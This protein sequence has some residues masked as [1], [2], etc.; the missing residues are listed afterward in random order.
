M[1]REPFLKLFRALR[2]TLDSDDGEAEPGDEEML[3][4]LDYS[5]LR[6]DGSPGFLN[7]IEE[8]RRDVEAPEGLAL[9]HIVETADLLDV[10]DSGVWLLVPT[11]AA[12]LDALAA[13]EV[14]AEDREN[15]IE[16]E[17]QD[18]D[19]DTVNDNAFDTAGGWPITDDY[20]D[21]GPEKRARFAAQAERQ[22][23]K[24]DWEAVARIKRMVRGTAD[25]KLSL[26]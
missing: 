14:E 17:P 13:F 11:T 15:D 3:R 4:A 8:L 26:R 1:P 19:D 6:Q 5:F 21:D 12:L 10:G 20:E 16:D 2:K 7:T 24:H 23:G 9:R 22:R 25:M 18:E